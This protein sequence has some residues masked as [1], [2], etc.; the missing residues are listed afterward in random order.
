MAITESILTIRYGKGATNNKNNK[1][2]TKRK[3]SIR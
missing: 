1:Q 3:I 2:K